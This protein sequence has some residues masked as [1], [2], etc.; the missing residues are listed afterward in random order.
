VP[1]GE[2]PAV[3][4]NRHGPQRRGLD[5]GREG[6]VDRSIGVEANE[7]RVARG[8]DPSGGLNGQVREVRLLEHPIVVRAA[9]DLAIAAEARVEVSRSRNGGARAEAD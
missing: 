2:E 8:H 4:L 6:V 1:G 7:S 5:L 3:V 9:L